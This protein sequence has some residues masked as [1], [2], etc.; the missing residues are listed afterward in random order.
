MPQIFSLVLTVSGLIS[1]TALQGASAAPA[2]EAPVLGPT[3]PI[4]FGDDAAHE[5]SIPFFE[6]AQYDASVADPE[7]LFG[8]PIGSRLA[9]HAEMLTMLRAIA[10]TSDRVTIETYGRTCLLYTSPSPRDRQKSRMPSSA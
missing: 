2:Q 5:W 9:S 6:G 4:R 7:V 1:F 8:Q 10:D 3:E